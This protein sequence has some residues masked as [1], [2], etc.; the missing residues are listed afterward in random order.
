MRGTLK[1]NFTTSTT[2][3]STPLLVTSLKWS[4]KILNRWDVV[5]QHQLPESATLLADTVLGVTSATKVTS[6]PTSFLRV[7]LQQMV[8]VP[9]SHP[10]PHPP[11]RSLTIAPAPTVTNTAPARSLTIAPAPMVTNTAPAPTV[12]NT[13]PAPPMALTALSSLKRTLGLPNLPRLPQAI[14]PS[15]DGYMVGPATVPTQ[16]TSQHIP[17]KHV[18]TTT[19]LKCTWTCI[20]ECATN[21]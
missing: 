14:T 17:T 11:V 1:S 5:L 7:P 20:R 8:S 10:I 3:V 4:G 2:Q 16:L 9:I 15:V 13:A 19:A 18:S 6:K 21:M 12:T